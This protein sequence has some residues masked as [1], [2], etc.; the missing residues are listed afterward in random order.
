MERISEISK[1]L[2][3][4]NTIYTL[5]IDIQAERKYL[6]DV[7]ATLSLLQEECKKNRAE[8]ASI[9][10]LLIKHRSR[11]NKMP[12]L[13]QNVRWV[14]AVSRIAAAEIKH[15]ERYRSA[16]QKYDMLI[17]KYEEHKNKLSALNHEYIE[18]IWLYRVESERIEEW[19]SVY[20]LSSEEISQA[21]EDFL[22]SIFH[23]PRMSK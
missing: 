10:N 23:L 14:Q 1:L 12:A 4:N 13:L 17:L 9:Q 22:N 3:M 21:Q 5:K 15:K 18:R 2:E 8:L 16:Q 20:S 19:N 6:E 7:Q 11:E